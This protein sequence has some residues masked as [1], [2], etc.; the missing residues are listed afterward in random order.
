MTDQSE[1]LFSFQTV[2]SEELDTLNKLRINAFET[3]PRNNVS[4]E[5]KKAHTDRAFDRAH[6]ANLTGLA[7]SGGGIRSATFNLGVMQGLA[8]VREEDKGRKNGL[9]SRFDYLSTVS[10]GG[11]IGSWLSA[12][13]HRDAEDLKKAGEPVG[14]AFLNGM[15]KKISTRPCDFNSQE[16]LSSKSTWKNM[17]GFDE[18]PTTSGFPPLEHAAVR[19]LRRYSNYLAPRLGLSGDTLSLVSLFLRNLVALQLALFTFI[20]IFIFAGRAIAN[21]SDRIV[22]MKD[23]PL[24]GFLSANGL[25]AIGVAL[26]AIV[27]ALCGLQI[28]YFRAREKDIPRHWR[29][30]IPAINAA[31]AFAVLVGAWLVVM[32]GMATPPW[33]PPLQNYVATGVVVYAVVWLFAFDKSLGSVKTLLTKQTLRLVLVPVVTG[34]TLGALAYASAKVLKLDAVQN[35]SNPDTVILLGPPIMLLVLSFVV[36]VHII[37]AGDA[38]SQAQREWWA[39][40][41]GFVLY[42]GVLWAGLIAISLYADD[43]VCWLDTTAMPALIAWLGASGGGAWLARQ[44]G[45]E[46]S[47]EDTSAIKKALTRFVIN[48]A[49]FVFVIGLAIVVSL[50]VGWVIDKLPEVDAW[51]NLVAEGWTPAAGALATFVIFL[52]IT[53]FLDINI[54]SLHTLYKNRLVRAYLGASRL[55]DRPNEDPYTAFDEDDDLK[56]VEINDQR[57]VHLVNGTINMTGGSDLAWQTRRAAS[58]TFTPDYV[59][60]ESKSTSGKDLGGFRRTKDYAAQ[61]RK[62]P[63]QNAATG[64]TLG[65]AMA[66]S[67]AAASPNMGYNTSSG[68]AALLTI[69]NMRLGYWAGNPSKMPDWRKPRSWGA[70]RKRSPLIAARPIWQDLTGSADAECPW[71]NLTD[72]GHFDNLGIYELARRR[73]RLIVV[74]D[75]GCDPK[76]RFRDL[77]NAIRLCWTDLGVHIYMP[78]LDLVSFENEDDRTVRSHGCF[79]LIE[80]ADRERDDPERY[81]LILYLKA[82]LTDRTLSS[83]ADIRQY[84]EVNRAYP[85]E[86]TGDQFFD[87]NQFEAYRHLG[88]CVAANVKRDL[89]RLFEGQTSEIR[90]DKGSRFDRIVKLIRAR[91]KKIDKV[92]YFR[93]IKQRSVGVDPVG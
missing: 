92:S 15:Q 25:V 59:G 72:G 21:A 55:G 13:V 65:T 74:T 83:Y 41:G 10:G 8:K 30:R 86:T 90:M 4:D 67:G 17:S 52:V 49:P 48:L 11:Y 16:S 91:Q 93:R 68:I 20:A 26:L 33:I 7:F 42:A 2:L 69:F 79:G 76:H 43:F 29:R 82:S 32:S 89:E 87:E 58:F 61:P 71:V 14:E 63:D 39:R 77:A 24:L 44:V 36:T 66:I 31:L 47:Q 81:G 88:Y 73:C 18:K 78:S 80:Y 64:I 37:I 12:W 6:D 56:L 3:T 57:P 19:Y 22:L 62:D 70:W 53:S 50:T 84:A 38:I 34:A 85:H 45:K 35:I 27:L 1:T 23:V 40:F 28:W 9:L 5:E 60:F 75:A 51:E 46:G 54:F